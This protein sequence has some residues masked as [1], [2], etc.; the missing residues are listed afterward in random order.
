MARDYLMFFRNRDQRR[1]VQCGVTLAGD[2]SGRGC[3]FFLRT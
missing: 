3:Y 2:V 1:G